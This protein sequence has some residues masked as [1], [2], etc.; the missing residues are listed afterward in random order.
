M[1]KVNYRIIDSAFVDAVITDIDGN[2][3]LEQHPISIV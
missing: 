2:F 1:I 3:M